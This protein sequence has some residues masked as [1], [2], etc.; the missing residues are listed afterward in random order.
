MSRHPGLGRGSGEDASEAQAWNSAVDLPGLAPAHALTFSRG[1]GGEHYLDIDGLAR[2]IHRDRIYAVGLRHGLKQAEIAQ[3]IDQV[4][5]AVSRW[6]PLPYKNRVSR[7][8]RIRVFDAF[9]EV[10]AQF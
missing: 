3:V 1:P 8:S 4:L 5:N 2:N 9:R 10:D 7:A 6:S